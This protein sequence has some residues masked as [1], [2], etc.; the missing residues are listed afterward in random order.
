MTTYFEGDSNT[1]VLQNITN[2]IGPV[3]TSRHY[4]S[5]IKIQIRLAEQWGS[6]HT[7]HDEGYTNIANYQRSLDP[8]KGLYL[9]LYY[10]NANEQ[11]HIKYIVV[12]ID[13]D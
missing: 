9:E 5:E 8:S 13:L 11:Y 6:C 10:E 1:N 4:S 3:V 12:N 2:I 7:E